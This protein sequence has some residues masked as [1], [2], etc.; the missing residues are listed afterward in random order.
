MQLRKVAKMQ[1]DLLHLTKKLAI[2]S[3][4][5]R[6]KYHLMR[7]KQDCVVSI[8]DGMKNIDTNKILWTKHRYSFSQ[9]QPEQ[10]QY[11]ESDFSDKIDGKHQ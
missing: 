11:Q 9:S 4:L 2:E 7:I 10:F 6:K 1:K 3:L 8:L 5:R